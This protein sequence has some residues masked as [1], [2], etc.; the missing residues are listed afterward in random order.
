MREPV[1]AGQSPED[2]CPGKHED[3]LDI[4]QDEEH[5]DHIEADGEASAG[6]A[7][8]IH[9]ALVGAGLGAGVFVFADEERGSHHAAGQSEG[10]QNLKH[11][12]NVVPDVWVTVHGHLRL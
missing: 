3:G 2:H 4:E 8:R 1:M 5:R 7:D 9:A 6:V 12:W 10:N 11:E